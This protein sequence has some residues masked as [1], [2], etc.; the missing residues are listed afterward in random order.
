MKELR[1]LGFWAFHS[2]GSLAIPE[3]G[4]KSR[5]EGRRHP[6]PSGPLSGSG[7]ASVSLEWVLGRVQGLCLRPPGEAHTAL[8]GA[9]QPP[10][11]GPRGGGALGAPV[12]LRGCGQGEA[13]AHQQQSGF[14]PCSA[15]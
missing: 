3:T 14:S 2:A 6:G 8:G 5:V 4:V 10:G 13:G 1:S 7:P 11:P 9:V 12:E 15:A